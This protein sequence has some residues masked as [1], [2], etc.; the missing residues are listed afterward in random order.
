MRLANSQTG[1]DWAWLVKGVLLLKQKGKHKVNLGLPWGKAAAHVLFLAITFFQEA[2]HSLSLRALKIGP[3]HNAHDNLIHVFQ[4]LL[5]KQSSFANQKTPQERRKKFHSHYNDHGGGE[6]KAVLRSGSGIGLWWHW[7][8]PAAAL[9]VPGS[10]LGNPPGKLFSTLEAGKMT[11]LSQQL[12][13]SP[14][15]WSLVQTGTVGSAGSSVVRRAGRKRAGE[16][17]M[18]IKD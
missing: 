2:T 5:Y 1:F 15:L 9:S 12:R 6:R 11:A 18:F 10:V 14:A 7:R 8:R 4:S 3:K 13:K 17:C 16:K